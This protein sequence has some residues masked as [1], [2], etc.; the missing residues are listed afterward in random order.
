[1]SFLA[2]RESDS[3]LVLCPNLGRGPSN[4]RSPRAP[5]RMETE[6]INQVH[7]NKAAEALGEAIG[8]LMTI[9]D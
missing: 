6:R 3:Q 9:P 8:T 7:S 2:K 1:M 5:H 4:A